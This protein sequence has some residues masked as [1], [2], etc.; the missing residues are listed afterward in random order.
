MPAQKGSGSR[1]QPG[2]L[3][4]WLSCQ[5]PVLLS[6]AAGPSCWRP[7]GEW[8]QARVWGHARAGGRGAGSPV[9][10]VL[11]LEAPAAPRTRAGA[12]GPGW[13][14]PGPCRVAERRASWS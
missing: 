6:E 13:G 5:G 10:S 4:P 7:C 12:R 1:D 2:G 14:C 8:A 11:R 9:C 3:R